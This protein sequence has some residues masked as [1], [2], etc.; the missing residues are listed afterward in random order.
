MKRF[1]TTFL[2]CLAMAM[3]G[4]AVQPS[5]VLEDPV[6]EQRARNLSAGLRCMVCQNQSIDDSDAELARDLRVLVRERLV[7]GETDEQVIDYVVSRYGEFVLLKPRFNT[8][9]ALLWST[10]A[11]LLLLGAGALGI[12]ASRRKSMASLALSDDEER[13]LREILKNPE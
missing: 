13:R 6:L 7:A 10:P 2:F 3:P 4:L 9:N 8:R 5:E 12:Y 1:F 11:I